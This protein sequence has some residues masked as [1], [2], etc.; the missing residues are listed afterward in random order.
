M[1]SR[2]VSSYDGARLTRHIQKTQETTGTKKI[3]VA[4]LYLSLGGYSKVVILGT[5]GP[6]NDEIPS[7]QAPW[8]MADR[9]EYIGE[10]SGQSNTI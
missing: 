2:S 9:A 1:R 4:H 7:F 6:G 3:A 5:L 8:Q 10:S